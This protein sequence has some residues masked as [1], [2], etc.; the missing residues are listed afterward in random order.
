MFKKV[1]FALAVA[2]VLFNFTAFAQKQE[3]AKEQVIA[4]ATKAVQ[5]KGYNLT[6]VKII[7]DDGSK[8]WQERI[9]VLTLPVDAPNYGV[10]KRGFLKNYMTVYFDFREPMKDIWVFVDKDTGEVFEVYSE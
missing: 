1:L 7:Y 2:G 8:L 9:G 5:D 6:E 10:L 4:I 3:F